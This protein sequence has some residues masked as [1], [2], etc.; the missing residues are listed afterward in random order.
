MASWALYDREK[1][2]P[3]SARAPMIAHHVLSIVAYSGGLSTGRM[4]FWGNFDGCCEITLIFLT[5]LQA[6]KLKGGTFRIAGPLL[7]I[8]GICLWLSF[9]VFRIVLFPVWLYMFA[10]GGAPPKM[11]S[12]INSALPQIYKACQMKSVS[13]SQFLSLVSIQRSRY[14]YGGSRGCGL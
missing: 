7:L 2:L 10:Q 3:L 6:S 13:S 1:G 9:L 4:L 12:H 11:N 14:F 8:N 5:V